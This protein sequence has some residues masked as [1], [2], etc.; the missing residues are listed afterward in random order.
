[1]R[2]V[3]WLFGSVALALAACSLTSL[4]G[5]DRGNGAVPP[6]GGDGEA[7]GSTPPAPNPA[8]TPPG[9]GDGGADA[10]TGQYVTNAG[11]EAAGP[12]CGPGW[13]ADQIQITRVPGENGGSACQL[14]WPGGNNTGLFYST[15]S[16]VVDGGQ[17]AGVV[18]YHLSDGGAGSPY[19]GFYLHRDPSI[20][21]EVFP[22]LDKAW[23][24]G[25]VYMN[26]VPRRANLEIGFEMSDDAFCVVV[27]GVDVQGPF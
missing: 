6:D 14:C 20:D 5:F 9:A 7:P 18:R 2:P 27:D 17:F 21:E 8:P 1:M 11:F 26:E 4:D 19:F 13:S 25:T 15:E 10:A 22:T 3:R 24:D 16:I 12:G 23:Q